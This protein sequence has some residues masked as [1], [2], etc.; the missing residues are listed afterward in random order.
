MSGIFGVIRRDGAPLGDALATM[1]T[2]MPRWGPD[3]FGEW[4]DGSAGLGQARLVSTPESRF[5]D[6]PAWDGAAG[7]AFT[8]AGRLD[9]RTALIA[10]L[11]L[12]EAGRGLG[13]GGVMM[14]AYRR[15]GENTPGRLLG[16]WSF[17]A[18]HPAQRR[19]FVA[20]DQMGRTALYYHCNRETVAFCCSQR[21]LLALGMTPIVLDEL[22]LAQY[23]I[24]WPRYQG[25][26]TATSAAGRLPP[27]HTVTVTERAVRTS[28]Y[29]RLEDQAVVRLPARS[30]YVTVLR[31]TFDDAVRSRLRATGPL[32]M[33][34]SGGLDSSAVA[35]TAAEQLRACGERLTAFTSVPIGPAR[36]DSR[37]FGDELP[38]VR[39]MAQA[40]GNIDVV[41]VSASGVSPIDG[42][43]WALEVYGAPIHAASNMFWVLELQRQARAA[44]CRVLLDGARG[45][46][47]ISWGGDPLSARLVGQLRTLGIRR[48]TARRVR[49]ALPEVAWRQLSRRRVNPEWYRGSAIH[50]EFAQRLQL[51]QRRLEDPG[52][53]P[54]APRDHRLAI[55]KPGRTIVGSTSAELGGWFGI[56]SRDPTADARVLAFTMSV[57]DGIFRSPEDGSSG[58]LIREAMRGRVPEQV[59]LNR[60]KGLQAADLVNRLRA[61]SEDVNAA[62]EELRAG[63]AV[64]Y[65]DVDH[66]A[67]AW[68]AIQREDSI[69]THRLA[70]SV[71]TR[72]IMGGLFANGVVTAAP[73]II[74]P[75]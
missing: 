12:L 30:D 2:A 41:P 27:A 55:L 56:D 51:G 57:P 11:G 19:L 52:T 33:M 62:L 61:C 73:S 32:G 26:R 20:R 34:L 18:W 17:A 53:R 64:A 71:L 25:H 36:D 24:S 67:N 15:W 4:S 54:R 23:L 46:G 14:A 49:R 13:D 7:F 21:A 60:R 31:Q 48:W 22:Y 63:P 65:V 37:V 47:G 10:E 6:L 72:G 70:V 74:G 45:N 1:R 16:D 28:C 3:G 9:N 42:I 69:E 58:W 39:T 35:A 44:G 29:W 75:S 68:R 8:A 40:A 50:P 5:E 66:M 38:L 43:R 59:R